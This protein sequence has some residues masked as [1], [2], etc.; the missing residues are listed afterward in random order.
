MK[1]TIE[2]TSQEPVYPAA[3]NL[4]NSCVEK[5]STK[6]VKVYEP[7]DRVPRDHL[8]TIQIIIKLDDL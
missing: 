6:T 4:F 2:G 1:I 5:Y 7:K 8:G 3:I